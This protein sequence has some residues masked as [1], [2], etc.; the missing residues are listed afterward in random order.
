M[1]LLFPFL[2]LKIS[3]HSMEPAIKNGQ[4]VLVNR[5]SYLFKQPK[6]K[7]IVAFKYGGKV[8]IKRITKRE[9]GKYFLSGD[10]PNDSMDSRVFGLVAKRAIIGKFVIC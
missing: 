5:L 7:E 8:L 10:N 4:T 6:I 1:F 9:N 2:I 3:G